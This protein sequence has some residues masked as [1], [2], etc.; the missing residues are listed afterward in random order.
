MF[1]SSAI[2]LFK[3]GI[4]GIFKAFYSTLLDL[5]ALRFFYVG[6]KSIDEAREKYGWK[7]SVKKK[8]NSCFLSGWLAGRTK[9]IADEMGHK[10][11]PYIEYRAV[12]DVFRTIDPP[13]TLHT[14]SVS[15]P[16][17][18]RGG[19]GGTNAPGGGGGGGQ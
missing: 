8:K 10:V 2:C 11:L 17:Q 5:P 15:S 19:G 1:R 12:S 16:H 9:T 3:R 13:P 6:A 4:F 14:A 18:R 7:I